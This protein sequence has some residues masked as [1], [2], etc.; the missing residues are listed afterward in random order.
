VS[1]VLIREERAGVLLLQLNRPEARNAVNSELREALRQSMHD[2]AADSSLRVAIITGTGDKAFCAGADL[3][4]LADKRVGIPPADYFAE[5]APD[6][7][8][9]KPVI[10]AVNGAAYAGGFRLAQF[11]DLCI[12]SETA[13]F[14]ISEAKWSR[15]A[16]WAAPL[17]TM[18]PRRIVAELL[19]TAQ[20]ITA[21]RAYDVGLINE[22]VPPGKLMDRAW[23]LAATIVDNAP[24][25]ITACKWLIRVAGE[26]GVGATNA[27]ATEIF[28]HVY[29]SED[30]IEG[31]KAFREGRKP[32]WQ[33]R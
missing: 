16:P 22:V 4:E 13:K 32:V 18:L 29:T 5:F 24:L 9:E 27:I 8:I 28:R 10:T 30:A 19:L 17:T 2:F 33:G 6:D 11:G 23:E 25:T 20:P 7:W 14:A 26:A 21:Q 31:P 12:A 3:K 1:D 15:G